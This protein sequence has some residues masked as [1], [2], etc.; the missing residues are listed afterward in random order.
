MPK[1]NSTP[2]NSVHAFLKPAYLL[3]YL[4]MVSVLSYLVFAVISIDNQASQNYPLIAA[5][6]I[7]A[8]V[9][10]RGY[11]KV[12]FKVVLRGNQLTTYSL[13][14]KRTVLLNQLSSVEK[15]MTFQGFLGGGSGVNIELLRLVDANSNRTYLQLG[16]LNT[17]TRRVLAELLRS[18][19]DRSSITTDERSAELI[20]R[21]SKP[22]SFWS[23]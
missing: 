10:A 18:T 9:T 5:V 13:L 8:L 23:S 14:G 15:S 11:G 21:W 22:E 4:V 1:A 2:H 6:I 19:L 17:D 16:G 3:A 20:R 7:F 12:P